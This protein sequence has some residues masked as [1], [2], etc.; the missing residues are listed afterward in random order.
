MLSPVILALAALVAGVI[1]RITGL[2]FVLVLTAPVVLLYGAVPGTALSVLLALAASGVALP[3]VWREVDWRRVAWLLVP[4]L[5]IAPLGAW[6]VNAVPEAALLLLVAGFATLGLVASRI[7]AMSVLFRGRPGTVAAGLG[8]GFL[9]VTSGLSGPVLAAHAVGTR[10]DQRSFTS[11]VQ[12]VF[13]GLSLISVGFRG[14][15]PVPLL[16]VVVGLAATGV[17][18]GVGTMLARFVQPRTARR[19]MLAIAWAG[20]FVVAVRGV[21]ALLG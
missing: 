16:D 10:W 21:I 9:H 13:V 8:A 1:Q 4:A 5:V 17:G 6:V 18:I 12:A 19:G 11:S 3:T 14:W 15:P 2:G 20:T 7:P